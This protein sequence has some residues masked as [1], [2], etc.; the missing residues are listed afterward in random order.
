MTKRFGKSAGELQRWYLR[1][2]R[3]HRGLTQEQLAEAIDSTKQT[4]SRME[5]GATP[6]NQPFLEA[7]AETLN[8]HPAELLSRDPASGQDQWQLWNEIQQ[9]PKDRIEKVRA[10]LALLDT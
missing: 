10:M 4:V 3:K 7:C 1:E 6:Y 5:S 2:W 9:L 8:C